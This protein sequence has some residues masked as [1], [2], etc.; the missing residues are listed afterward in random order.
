MARRRR[1]RRPRRKRRTKR[2]R[3][4]RRITKKFARRVI[5]RAAER[6][7]LHYPIST[8]VSS[9]M[10]QMF[11]PLSIMTQDATNS[12]FIGHKFQLTS[13]RVNGNFKPGDVHNYLRMIIFVWKD[14]DVY[15]ATAISDVLDITGQNGDTM[16]TAPYNIENA[17]N[18]QILYDKTY[19]LSNAIYADAT[20]DVMTVP[21]ER[22]WRNVRIKLTKRLP[23]VDFVAGSATGIV[24][25]QLCV[26]LISDS[27]TASHPAADLHFRVRYVD[28]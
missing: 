19:G 28:A 5:T 23:E 21:L 6:K 24:R 27:G 4:Y 12:G 10:L 17:G 20:P 3:S 13:I 8:T 11:Y 2:R 15:N 22:F 25:N 1:T 7:Y 26:A 16:V 14:S 18:Y 9:S